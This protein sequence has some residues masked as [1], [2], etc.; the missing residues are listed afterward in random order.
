MDRASEY[1][2]CPYNSLH[3]MPKNRLQQHLIK[4]KRQ[5]PNVVVRTCKFNLTHV[6]KESD[7]QEHVL[8]CPDRKIIAEFM[9][10]GGVDPVETIKRSPTEDDGDNWDDCDYEESNEV[11]K[12]KSKPTLLVRA[13]GY[14]KSERRKFVDEEFKKRN[15]S[16]PPPPPT[17][18][19]CKINSSIEY[20]RDNRDE[21]EAAN[22]QFDDIKP[23]VSIKRSRSRSRSPLRSETLHR[24]VKPVV[25]IKRSRS[26]SRSPLRSETL[27]RSKDIKR[28]F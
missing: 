4:C 16:K 3:T 23:V 7:Y 5:H 25:S 9:S 22:V 26:R 14:T 24:D 20:M 2:L 13:Q 28:E 1:V 17:F 19:N 15:E 11:N 6:L 21:L 12:F 10:A 8:N 18:K 27:H